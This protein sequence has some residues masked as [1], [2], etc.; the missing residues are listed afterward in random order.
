SKK[1]KTNLESNTIKNI[2]NDLPSSLQKQYGILWGEYQLNT[3]KEAKF[4]HQLDKLEMA[5]QAKIYSDD[6]YSKEKL[7][8][9]FN[10]AEREITDTKLSELFKK[11]SEK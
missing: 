7:R 11:I 3:S 1:K 6:G 8:T 4:V 2:L 10:S 5:L 9:F